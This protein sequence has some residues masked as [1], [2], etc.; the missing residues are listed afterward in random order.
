MFLGQLRP[1]HMVP[2][3]RKV[4][5]IR[6]VNREPETSWRRREADEEAEESEGEREREEP[7]GN[8]SDSAPETA[9]CAEEAAGGGR[10]VRA[11]VPVTETGGSR[12]RG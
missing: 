3:L 7:Q 5:E 8:A 11:M 6:G 4:R 10:T 2:V 12:G 1:L 9:D